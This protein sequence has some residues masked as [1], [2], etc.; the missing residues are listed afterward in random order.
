MPK[1]PIHPVPI[2]DDHR[3]VLSG[4][5]AIKGLPKSQS[6]G[7]KSQSDQ[8]CESVLSGP[9]CIKGTETRGRK[10]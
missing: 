1:I 7:A 9:Q 8:G 2:E 6:K 4:K 3:S 5:D 10:K